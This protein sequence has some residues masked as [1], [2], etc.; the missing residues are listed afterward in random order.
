M[1][2]RATVEKQEREVSKG[3]SSPR[4]NPLWEKTEG[5]GPNEKECQRT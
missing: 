4:R 2:E 1:P 5:E 3:R